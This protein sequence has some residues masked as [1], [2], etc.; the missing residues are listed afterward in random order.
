MIV[1]KRVAWDYSTD[2]TEI[3][4]FRKRHSGLWRRPK[5]IS[6]QKSENAPHESKQQSKPQ[7]HTTNCPTSNQTPEREISI[8]ADPRQSRTA[9]CLFW[10]HDVC[11]A[12]DCFTRQRAVRGTSQS[13]PRG[14]KN[15][16]NC[17]E[18]SRTVQFFKYSFKLCGSFVWIHEAALMG[19]CLSANFPGGPWQENSRS[20]WRAN[21]NWWK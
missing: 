6:H 2:S 10:C 4:R 11:N 3:M 14:N 8:S 7:T 12:I 9:A 1:R 15:H 19:V 17:D 5:R 18:T 13:Q 16:E 20:T 21:R